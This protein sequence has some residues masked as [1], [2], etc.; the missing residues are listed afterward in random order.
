MHGF[1]PNENMLA[2]AQVRAELPCCCSG[3]SII[4]CKILAAATNHTRGGRLGHTMIPSVG[5]QERAKK[6]AAEEASREAYNKEERKKRY[7]E[8]GQ[9][10]ARR[11][12]KS[13]MADD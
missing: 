6:N 4:G 2:A 8:K 3:T 12:K 1:N 5:P 9:A 7:V 13:R 11:A 10:D